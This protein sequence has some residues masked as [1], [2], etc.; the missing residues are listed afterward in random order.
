MHSLKTSHAF[1]TI[2]RSFKVFKSSQSEDLSHTVQSQDFSHPA[3]TNKYG[4]WFIFM[5]AQNLSSCSGNVLC[6]RTISTWSKNCSEVNSCISKQRLCVLYMYT[7]TVHQKCKVWAYYAHTDIVSMLTSMSTST[8]SW[9]P[10]LVH[11][12]KK[13]LCLRVL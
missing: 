11:N 8:G 10:K 3:N 12:L 7:L 4:C 13:H 5:V 2:S 6:L 1:F 9:L